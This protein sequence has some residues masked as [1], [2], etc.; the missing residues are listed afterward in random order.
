MTDIP[1]IKDALASNLVTFDDLEIY[2]DGLKRKSDPY[3]TRDELVNFANNLYIAYN[4][5]IQ[6]VHRDVGRADELRDIAFMLLAMSNSMH[7]HTPDKDQS[8]LAVNSYL[9]TYLINTQKRL[10]REGRVTDLPINCRHQC[11]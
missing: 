6:Q 7:S 2:M 10:E 5:V 8:I 1:K 4:A 3:P 11:H 9:T